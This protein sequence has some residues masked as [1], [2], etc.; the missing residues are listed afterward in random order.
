M[1]FFNLTFDFCFVFGA[2]GN[3]ILLWMEWAV[4]ECLDFLLVLLNFRNFRVNWNRLG[5]EVMKFFYL[6]TSKF[7]EILAKSWEKQIFSRLQLS[8]TIPGA[9]IP[10]QFWLMPKNTYRAT[11]QQINLQQKTKKIIEKLN[12]AKIFHPFRTLSYKKAVET[13]HP[14][15]IDPQLNGNKINTQAINLG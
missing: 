6:F 13:G 15:K 11:C 8:L 5:S 14:F 10:H 3:S 4:I 12:Q 9:L 7:W 1:T 2:D